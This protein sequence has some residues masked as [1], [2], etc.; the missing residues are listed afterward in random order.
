VFSNLKRA[1]LLTCFSLTACSKPTGN[2]PAAQP[3]YAFLRFENLTGDPDLDWTGRALSESLPASLSGALDGP[4]LPSSALSRSSSSLGARPAV[5]PG[6]SSERTEAL[7]AGAT[8]IVTGYIEHRNGE[9]RITAVEEDV[10]TGKTLL[11][12]SASAN[13]PFDAIARLANKLS[14]RA[15]PPITQKPGALTPYAAGLETAQPAATTH[16]LQAVDV[17]P[18]FGAAWLALVG[19]DLSRNDRDS[20]LRDIA[21]A[22][23]HKIDSLSRASLDV[24]AARLNNDRPATIAA[25]RQLADLAPGDLFL[26]RA[27]ADTETNAGDFTAAEAT[28]MKVTASAPDDVLAWNSLGY[29]RSYAGNY[30][31]AI[32]AV[33]QYDRLRPKDANPQDSLG[34]INYQ[35]RKFKEAAAN[36]LEAYKRQPDFEQGGG[37]YKA[38]WA[39]FEADDKAGADAAFS[40]FRTTRTKSAGDVTNLL[41]ADWLF[42]TGRTTEAFS[43]ARG[44][45][46]TTQSAPLRTDLFAQLVIW[47]LLQGDRTAAARDAAVIGGQT[48]SAPVFIAR[49]AALPS[50]PAAEWQAR[51]AKMVAPNMSALRDLALGYALLFDGKRDAAIP[52]WEQVVRNS[53]ATDFFTRAI[54]TRLR[55]G[56]LTRPL[57]P[58]PNNLNQFAGILDKL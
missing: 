7:L 14:P 50:A 35:F 54:L 19:S 51:A 34:D 25:M 15:K 29:V 44:L 55:G 23:S 33:Q 24:E 45:G 46:S 43:L 12:V 3:R 22:R 27:L 17:D 30:P 20:T 18:D 1:L 16:F 4:V 39:R 11:T 40:Q 47:D 26:M 9:I 53:G 32:A 13:T 57:L 21:T 6:V 58:D 49:F 56:T 37:L 10:A 5:A 36:Y 38:A 48:S 31:G 28:W 2:V 42:R 41:S 8:R 52:V